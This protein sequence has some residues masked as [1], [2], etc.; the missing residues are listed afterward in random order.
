MKAMILPKTCN[1]DEVNEPLQFVEVDKPVFEKDEMLIKVAVCGVCHTELD[2]IEGRTSPTK[3][4]MILGHEVVGIVEEL[5]KNVSKFKIGD[6]VGVA[7]IYSAC[8]ECEFCRSGK[9]NL[10]EKFQAT[11]RDQKGGYAEYMKVKEKFAYPIPEIFTDQEAAPLLC[12]GG[13]G[14]RS[15]KL[16]E[17]VDGQK[18]GFTGFGASAHIVLRMAIH[19]Y[20][21]SEFYVFARNPKEREFAKELGAKWSG[22]I[23]EK[24]PEKLDA[25]ID[26]TPA[27][28]PV[29]EALTNLKKGG[30]LIINAIR[31][32]DKDKSFLQNILYHDHL[33]DEKEVK[34]VANVTRDDVKKCLEIASKIPVFPTT[35]E[36]P[37]AHANLALQELKQGKIKGAKILRISGMDHININLHGIDDSEK[38]GYLRYFEKGY[39]RMRK[40]AYQYGYE[41]LVENTFIKDA[42]IFGKQRDFITYLKDNLNADPSQL[43]KTISACLEDQIFLAVS[44]RTYSE[45][46]PEGIEDEAYSKLI[47]H[48]MAHRLHIRILQGHEEKMGNIWFF[49]GFAIYA[50]EQF[51]RK[52]YDTTKQKVEQII[53]GKE[54]TSYLDYATVFYNL[55]EK[56]SVNDLIERSYKPN[57]EQWIMKN[58]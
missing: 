17:L 5:G 12:A 58:L 28:K 15:L 8:G 51:E 14:Y 38:C 13:V 7:W 1:L 11:G 54:R 34:S 20:P 25:I 9:E 2:E 53:F 47:T 33:W 26:T 4:P 42:H 35:K 43:P 50:A 41:H 32:E 24:S 27:W 31:K 45:I 18:L 46:F 56:F 37:L 21:N 55:A 49:E 3:F 22:D 44:D 23:S 52:S 30:K 19:L 36:F 16:T 48:E 29:L 6:R 57:F 10:C 40:F 39:Q